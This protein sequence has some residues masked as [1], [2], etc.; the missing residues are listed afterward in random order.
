MTPWWRFILFEKTKL[1]EEL[2]WHYSTECFFVFQHAGNVIFFFLSG[3]TNCVL[4]FGKFLSNSHDYSQNIS[5]DCFSPQSENRVNVKIHRHLSKPLLFP[6]TLSKGKAN[7]W[8][9]VFSFTEI[10]IQLYS[11]QALKEP[12]N[13]VSV[14]SL[15]YAEYVKN[16]R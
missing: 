4:F 3:S 11:I 1:K 15:L 16:D 10:S 12:A 6:C 7:C 13:P 9:Q 8:L 2:W 14:I 5:N